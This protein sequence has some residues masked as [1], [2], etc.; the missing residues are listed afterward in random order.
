MEQYRYSPLRTKTVESQSSLKM[1]QAS[2][3]MPAGASLRNGVANNKI[4]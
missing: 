1:L 4:P 3:N 2:M